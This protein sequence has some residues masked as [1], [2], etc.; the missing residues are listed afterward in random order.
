MSARDRASL[1]FNSAT[2]GPKEGGG[3]VRGRRGQRVAA[4]RLSAPPPQPRC[5]PKSGRA[6][7][8]AVSSSA[9]R[10]ASSARTSST[11][12]SVPSA[13]D[14]SPAAPASAPAAAAWPSPAG[15][16]GGPVCDD[17]GR[18][19]AAGARQ[20][21]ASMGGRWHCTQSSASSRTCGGAGRA[22]ARAASSTRRA[23]RRRRIVG[24]RGDPRQPGHA[25]CGLGF[26]PR[27]DPCWDAT[28]HQCQTGLPP[29]RPATAVPGTATGRPRRRTHRPAVAARYRRSRCSPCRAATPRLCTSFVTLRALTTSRVRSV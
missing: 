1:S 20:G 29:P 22:R 7:A 24:K 17:Q 11:G 8:L 26:T 19:T 6:W 23:S 5:P 10:S 13:G 16:W 28:S 14:T 9:S 12:G 15:G 2:Y 18:H 4:R 25:P 21:E 3:R 27:L